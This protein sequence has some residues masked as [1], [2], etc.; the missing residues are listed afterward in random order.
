MPAQVAEARPKLTVT[1]LATGLTIP[2]DIT[3][4]GDV[5]LFNERGRQVVVQAGR[6]GQA[7]GSGAAG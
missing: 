6:V 5:M 1:T 2:W 4:V 7:I 3:W